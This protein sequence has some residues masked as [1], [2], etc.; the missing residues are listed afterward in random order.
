MLKN[1]YTYDYVIQLLLWLLQ[2]QLVLQ[3]LL[4]FEFQN[5]VGNKLEVEVGRSTY[6]LQV[7]DVIVKSLQ[8]MQ[9][10]D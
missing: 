4:V 2:L 3:L 1:W 8:D 9:H 6:Q 10:Y 7:Q 5:S